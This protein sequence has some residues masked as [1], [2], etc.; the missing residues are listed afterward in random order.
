MNSSPYGLRMVQVVGP[1]TDADAEDPAAP[2]DGTA[3][4]RL[5]ADYAEATLNGANVLQRFGKD[6]PEFREADYETGRVFRQIR[7]LQGLCN[8]HWM[9]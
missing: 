7:E 1:G 9:E 8:R 3:L 6:S 5:T 4:A 2:I